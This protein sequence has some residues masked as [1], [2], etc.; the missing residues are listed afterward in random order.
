MREAR[1]RVVLALKERR[2]L[3]A[4]GFVLDQQ[5]LE[6]E[7]AAV[8]LVE[9]LIYGADAALPEGSA[10]AVASSHR[11]QITHRNIGLTHARRR[12]PKIVSSAGC[13]RQAR[14]LGD[15]AAGCAH[16]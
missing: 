5:A 16:M 14:K 1:E 2:E 8:V 11:L 10:Q 7:D 3:H 4:L 9:R 6:S 12:T 13:A 15:A